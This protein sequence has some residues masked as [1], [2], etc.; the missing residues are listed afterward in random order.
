[1]TSKKKIIA[2][3]PARGGSVRVPNKNIRDFLGKPMIQY[4]IETLIS[5]Q[6]FDHIFVSTDSLE[7]ANVARLSGAEV[8]FLRDES[9]SGPNTPT[10][11]V[12]IDALVKIQAD[13]AEVCCVYATNPF[14]YKE[15]LFLGLD[16]LRKEETS[17]YV[18]PVVKYSF[19]IQRSLVLK[20]NYL[21]INQP[22]FLYSRSQDL[23]D[24]YH[25][26]AQF[27]WAN[28]STWLSRLDMQSRIKG[29][30]IPEWSQQDIDT[31]E[32]WELAEMKYKLLKNSKEWPIKAKNLRIN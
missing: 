8:P 20:N 21:T 11:D 28:S 25:E 23:E 5:S 18:T 1:M 16:V 30:I 32:D 13:D 29:I 7:I 24:A 4:T 19:P 6:I 22:E 27:W 31:P 3:I 10:I 9:L 17:C 14:L 2:V 15:L 26:S 12:I